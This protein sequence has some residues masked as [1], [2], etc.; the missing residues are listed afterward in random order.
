[1]LNSTVVRKAMETSNILK[2]NIDFG[3]GPQQSSQF[4]VDTI[5][6]AGTLKKL[7]YLIKS[8]PAGNIDALTFGKR[9][10]RLHNK[11]VATIP[12]GNNNS[13][14]REIPYAV[15][16]CDFDIWLDNDDLYYYAAREANNLKQQPDLANPNNLE[17]L[18]ISAQQKML[19]MD[20]QDLVFN[21]DTEFPEAGADYDFLKIM[22]GFVK[23]LSDS[24]NKKDLTTD[25]LTLDTFADTVALLP[26][27]F[28]SN[29]GEDIKW[30][31]NQVTADK[32]M[33]LIKER[34][35]DYGDAIL[36]DGKVLRLF[37]Y[38][39]EIVAGMTGSL[40]N[41]LDAT[42][43]RNGFVVLTPQ[44]NLVP[45]T[46]YSPSVKYRRVGAETDVIAAKKD[47]TYHIWNVYLDAIVREIK[48][49]AILVGENV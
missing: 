21:G 31:M 28:R 36:K 26:E 6:R 43:G 18:V 42:A 41:Q 2:A 12:T 1:M 8:T 13:T 45:V 34:G 24:P 25:E 39:I 46:T 4:L 22:N 9:N 20:M 29:Y 48:A 10:L 5:N 23:Q 30:Y 37:G 49:S 47:A 3:M 32:V 7:P 17:Q 11:T 38:G 19:A 33:K 44:M 40:K 16:K 14:P 27:E 15:K 35:T